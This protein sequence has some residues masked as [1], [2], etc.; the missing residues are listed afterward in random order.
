MTVSGSRA[1]Q[2]HRDLG[3]EL[4][5][6]VRTAAEAWIPA[7][8]QRH[9]AILV[10]TPYMKESAAPTAYIDP[11]AATARGYAV[12]LEDV[13]GCGESE[14]EFE[15]FV[16]EQADGRDSVAWTARQPWCDGRVVMAGMSYLGA[17]QWLAGLSGRRPDCGVGGGGRW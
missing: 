5:D 7:D 15:P 11:R 9:P 8:G 16:N 4:R 10:R 12:V 14:G 17:A 1:I 6:G 3:I 13:R 2:I